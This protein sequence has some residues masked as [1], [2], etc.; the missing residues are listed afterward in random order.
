MRRRER[1]G[2]GEGRGEGRINSII[3]HLMRR[4]I[5]VSLSIN[6]YTSLSIYLSIS[7]GQ[8]SQKL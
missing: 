2:G 1:K 4:H 5:F 3:R 6:I 8:H 7:N